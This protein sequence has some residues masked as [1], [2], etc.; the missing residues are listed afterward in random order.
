MVE[1]LEQLR[2][3][4]DNPSAQVDQYSAVL[5]TTDDLRQRVREWQESYG[6]ETE[7]SVD[8]LNKVRADNDEPDSMY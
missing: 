2:Q 5:A 8:T 7:D 4:A 6:I 1:E 3:L